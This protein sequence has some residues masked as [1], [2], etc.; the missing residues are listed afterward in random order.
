MSIKA[1]DKGLNGRLVEVTEVRSCLARFV[2]HHE[3]LRVD[4]SEGVDNDFALD[5]LYGVHDDGDG[6]GG[7]LFERLLGVDIDGRQPAAETWM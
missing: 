2:A 6:A 7:Q 5:R 4:Q 1:V 3:R